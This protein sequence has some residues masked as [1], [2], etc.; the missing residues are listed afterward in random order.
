MKISLEHEGV[1]VSIEYSLETLDDAVEHVIKPALLAVGF[2]HD[3]VNK[4]TY[5]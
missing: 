3:N 4:I 1:K 5:E 2:H